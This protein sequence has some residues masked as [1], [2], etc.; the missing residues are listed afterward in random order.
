MFV[1]LFLSWTLISQ[2]PIA[3]LDCSVASSLYSFCT[4]AVRHTLP[5]NL[6]WFPFLFNFYFFSSLSICNCLIFYSGQLLPGI[7]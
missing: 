5:I 3:W 1:F 6:S 2:F 7:I 4:L